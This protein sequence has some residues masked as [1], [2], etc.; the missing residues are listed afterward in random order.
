MKLS[1]ENI[2]S[3]VADGRF[4]GMPESSYV[5]GFDDL[6]G[7]Y[8]P[9]DAL[10]AFYYEGR[11]CELYTFLAHAEGGTEFYLRFI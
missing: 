2:Q 6:D 3:L 9:I 11:D 5:A 1:K 8:Y 4:D 10:D 7:K